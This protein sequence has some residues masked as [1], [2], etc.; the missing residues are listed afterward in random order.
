MRWRR[1]ARSTRHKAEGG[2][3]GPLHGVPVG[4]KDIFDT[5]DLPTEYGSPFSPAAGRTAD[6]AASRSCA[7]PARSS[8]ARR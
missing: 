7:R 5:A 6:A 2:R 3:I 8:S 4:I 1:R